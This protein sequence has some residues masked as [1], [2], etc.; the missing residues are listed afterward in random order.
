MGN[1][2]SAAPAKSATSVI[3]PYVEVLEGSLTTAPPE[4]ITSEGKNNLLRITVP[5]DETSLELGAGSRSGIRMTTAKHVEL[6]AKAPWT[7]ISLGEPGGYEAV[8]GINIQTDG[9]KREL[10]VGKVEETY[11]SSKVETV[12]GAVRE[13]YKDTKHEI[14]TGKVDH[15]YASTKHDEVLGD[16]TESIGGSRAVKIACDEKIEIHGE[17][18]VEVKGARH[19]KVG[20]HDYMTTIGTSNQLFIGEKA[21]VNLGTTNTLNAGAL[22]TSTNIGV[23][24]STNVGLNKSFVLACKLETV[25]GP[26]IA[27]TDNIKVTKDNIGAAKTEVKVERTQLSCKSVITEVDERKA[28]L[29]KGEINMV[30]FGLTVLK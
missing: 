8:A 14:V 13:V 30:N 10:V 25:I 19:L 5:A 20:S 2:K 12:T 28:G 21:T 4:P 26:S 15:F 23:N 18:K 17:Q 11:Q 7:R 29:S 6:T 22:N 16:V 24:V 3:D 9:E 27:T 1:T